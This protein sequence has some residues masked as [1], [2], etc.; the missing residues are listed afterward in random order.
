MSD[1]GNGGGPTIELADI[2]EESGPR[3]YVHL[4]LDRLDI[5]KLGVGDLL[6]VSEAC[7]ISPD[8]LGRALRN[9]TAITK[10][11]VVVALAWVIRRRRQ[12]ELTLNDAKTW[13][14]TASVGR[15]DPTPPA[16]RP[17]ASGGGSGSRARQGSR[18]GRSRG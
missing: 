2:L 14:I 17:S 13:H 3:E 9:G 4:A 16:P 7:G 10:A 11:Q 8:D 5:G 12:P 15:P 18:P 6:D 1:N